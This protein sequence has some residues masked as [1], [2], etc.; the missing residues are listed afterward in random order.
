MMG[1]PSL[2]GPSIPR[3]E[4]QLPTR[5]K[6][7]N[8][9][10]FARSRETPTCIE[11]CLRSCSG[12]RDKPDSIGFYTS[13]GFFNCTNPGATC[14][15]ASL[16]VCS[17]VVIRRVV[18]TG[19]FLGLSTG[20]D[21]RRLHQAHRATR[22]RAAGGRA[23]MKKANAVH[24]SAYREIIPEP[25]GPALHDRAS[26]CC[27]CKHLHS[28]GLSSFRRSWPRCTAEPGRHQVAVESSPPRAALY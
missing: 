22:G 1:G 9:G 8:H 20:E 13:P 25:A 26:K 23:E 17:H 14:F 5:R 7:N 19:L 18:E 21:P 11:C 15:Q 16:S 24:A 27:Q 6:A 4:F 2:A 10:L 28:S 3:P 12:F